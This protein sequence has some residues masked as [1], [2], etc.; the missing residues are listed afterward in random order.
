MIYEGI[1]QKTF[2]FV[3][4][5]AADSETPHS[6]QPGFTCDLD[7]RR[8]P[9]VLSTWAKYVVVSL[10]KLHKSQ[11]NPRNLDSYRSEVTCTV[12]Y[13]TQYKHLLTHYVLASDAAL[14]VILLHN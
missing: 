1:L 6:C 10:V 2:K 8:G 13:I 5:L 12:D 4:V 14:R 11:H 9:S 7:I 3:D